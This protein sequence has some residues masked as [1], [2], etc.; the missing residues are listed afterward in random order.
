MRSELNARFD[1]DE[2]A[3]LKQFAADNGVSEAAAMRILV[4][5]LMPL[6]IAVRLVDPSSGRSIGTTEVRT[7]STLGSAPLTPNE[8]AKAKKASRKSKS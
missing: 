8:K 6:S 4:R 5:R 7:Q 1:A 3:F 2:R